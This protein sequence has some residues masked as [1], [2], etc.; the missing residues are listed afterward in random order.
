M[1]KERIGKIGYRICAVLAA[2][3]SLWCMGDN[4]WPVVKENGAAWA[5]RAAGLQAATSQEVPQ[6]E[7]SPAPQKEAVKETEPEVT[8][9]P[10]ATPVPVQ[11]KTDTELP[12][13]PAPTPDP[14]RE[15]AAVAATFMGG[16]EEINGFFVKD[17]SD[18]GLDLSEEILI[19][20]D[21]HVRMMR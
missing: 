15:T 1:R 18:S 9:L 20:P 4:L 11:E 16:G 5:L 3:V 7:A 13:L 8:S 10:T 19:D 6:A 21:V 2:A 12:V 17:T 14:E